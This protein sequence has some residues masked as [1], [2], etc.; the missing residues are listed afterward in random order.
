MFERKRDFNK[1]IYASF[2]RPK[3]GADGVWELPLVL[4]TVAE[5]GETTI[6]A[7]RRSKTPS[8]ASQNQFNIIAVMKNYDL[9]RQNPI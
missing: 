1:E 9:G 7:I 4:E 3:T 8:K 6:L 2:Y 5:A